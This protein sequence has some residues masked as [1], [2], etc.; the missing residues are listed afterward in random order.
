MK[1]DTCMD[2]FMWN[3]NKCCHNYLVWCWCSDL[4]MMVKYRGNNT[5]QTHNNAQYMAS[6]TIT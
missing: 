3:K 6:T 2:S 1:Y 5:N 4:R